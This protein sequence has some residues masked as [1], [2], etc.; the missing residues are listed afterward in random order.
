MTDTYYA[1]FH[2]G[3]TFTFAQGFLAN[4]IIHIIYSCIIAAGQ[5]THRTLG[6]AI[7]NWNFCFFRFKSVWFP[8]FKPNFLKLVILSISDSV[9][10]EDSDLLEDILPNNIIRKLNLILCLQCGGKAYS[11]VI[12]LIPT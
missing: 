8:S 12:K 2:R 6:P 7:S 9:P 10:D 3:T 5:I 1:S 4:S 11:V